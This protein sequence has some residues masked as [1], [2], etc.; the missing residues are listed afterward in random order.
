MVLLKVR[1][2]AYNR[3]F[4]LLDRDLAHTLDDRQDYLLIADLSP[5]DL[6]SKNFAPIP[7]DVEHAMA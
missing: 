5:E 4:T 3:Q 2:D 6:K 1:Y 7:A